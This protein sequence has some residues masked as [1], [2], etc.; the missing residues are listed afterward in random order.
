ML[1][2]PLTLRG[3]AVS[4][5]TEPAENVV[6]APM[7]IAEVGLP[8][9]LVRM[10]PVW[11]RGGNNEKRQA[12]LRQGGISVFKGQHRCLQHLVSDRE[13]HTHQD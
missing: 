4:R 12:Y 6:F 3:L 10:P 2:V 5:V 13:I 8:E 9:G 7:L 1:A 11:A